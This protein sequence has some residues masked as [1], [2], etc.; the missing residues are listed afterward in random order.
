[1]EDAGLVQRLLHRAIVR[2][3]ADKSDDEIFRIAKSCFSEHIDRSVQYGGRTAASVINDYLVNP[4]Y[5]GLSSHTLMDWAAEM[6]LE[7]YSTW[8]NTD[9]PFVVD[10]PYFKSIARTSAIYKLFVSMNR[11]RWL[12]AQSG[13]SMVFSDLLDNMDGF[14]EKIESLLSGSSEMLQRETYTEA[15]LINFRGQLTAV[16]EALDQAGLA[17]LAYGLQRLAELGEEMDRILTLIVRKAADGSEF[18]LE[19]V[20]GLL[21]KGYN[22]L[23]TSYTI[24]HKPA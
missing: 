10:S 8:P 20:H 22:G 19:Q 21:F 7:F 2:V 6:G 5:V 11:L 14:G 3:N 1:M 13:D 24:W 12:F 16:G 18:D 23:G 9:L 15:A 4:H 17:A